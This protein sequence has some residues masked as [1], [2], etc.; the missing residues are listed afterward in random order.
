M[1]GAR[2]GYAHCPQVSR[3]CSYLCDY[4]TAVVV[5]PGDNVGNSRN[6]GKAHHP[7]IGACEQPVGGFCE[8]RGQTEG[9]QAR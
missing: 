6:A 3:P 1:V 8:R 9:R 2:G 4:K 5:G 7:A